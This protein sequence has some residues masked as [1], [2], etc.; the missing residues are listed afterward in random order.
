MSGAQAGGT[1]G[2]GQQVAVTKGWCTSSEGRAGSWSHPQQGFVG[3]R[4]NFVLCFMDMERPLKDTK[5]K[6]K[7]DFCFY[8]SLW[9]LDTK[10]VPVWRKGEVAAAAAG[11][12]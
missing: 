8:K 4:I 9:C 1:A 7:S 5:Q 2:Q 6:Q 10:L 12:R 11:G 3:L